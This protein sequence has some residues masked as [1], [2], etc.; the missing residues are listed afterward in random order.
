MASVGGRGRRLGLCLVVI[1]VLV[2]ADLASKSAV[3]EWLGP[4]TEAELAAGAT[5]PPLVADRHGDH[6]ERYPLAGEWL[7]LMLNRNTGAA[8]GQLANV[9]YLLVWGRVAAIV[10]LLWLI[11]RAPARQGLYLTSLVLIASGALGNLYDNLFLEPPDNP[12]G[13]PFGAVRDFIDVYFAV[14]DWHFPT[15]NVADSCI[16][17]GA[18][19]LLLSGFGSRAEKA[20]APEDSGAVESAAPGAAEARSIAAEAGD[21]RSDRARNVS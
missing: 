21:A 18:V 6:H 2:G 17:V 13:H 15:F 3:F 20:E 19:F 4:K 5:P 7:A 8:F 9:P 14:W 12:P 1:V 16:S 10:L 11:C